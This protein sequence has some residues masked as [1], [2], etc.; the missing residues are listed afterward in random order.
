MHMP[1]LVYLAV[2]ALIAL[3]GFVIAQV[4]PGAGVLFVIFV[5]LM[6]FLAIRPQGLT[7]KPWG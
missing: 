6:I 1:V 4:V 7:G 3:V 2:A 5:S